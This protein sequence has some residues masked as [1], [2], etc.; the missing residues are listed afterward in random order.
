MKWKS[1]ALILP[2]LLLF[3]AP[4][5]ASNMGLALRIELWS[6]PEDLHV[7]SLPYLG[8]PTTAKAMC[9]NLGGKRH[10]SGILHRDEVTSESTGETARAPGPRPFL[11]TRVVLQ[12]FRDGEEKNESPLRGLAVC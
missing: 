11:V 5:P 9:S 3:A 1:S 4:L 2:A 8:A 12:V 10:V 6:T 7:V